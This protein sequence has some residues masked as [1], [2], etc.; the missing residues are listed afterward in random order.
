M[1][2]R[3][4]F[5]RAITIGVG[6]TF[7]VAAHLK[8]QTP[9]TPASLSGVVR[10]VAGAPLVNVNITLEGEG[11]IT[12]TDTAGHFTLANVPTGSHATLF[13][14]I[15]YRSVEYRWVAQPNRGLQ[16]AVAMTPA[17]RALERVVVEAP[18]STRRRGT[19]SIGGTVSDSAGKGV[20]SADVRLLGSGLSTTT[21]SGGTFEFQSLAAGAY[22]VRARRAGVASG[23]YV[24]QLADDDNRGITLKLYGLPKRVGARDS[25][26]ASGYGVADVPFDAF[27]RR[28]RTNARYPILGPADLFRRQGASLDITLQQ[29]RENVP[30]ARDQMNEGDCLIVDGRRATSQPLRTFTSLDVQMVEIFRKN[31]FVDDYVVTQMDGIRECRGTMDHHPPYFVLWTRRLR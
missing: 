21:D 5:A 2:A 25:A 22:I 28:A 6:L 4:S 29:Y 14:R 18:G 1:A 9:A 10:D 8:A 23:N 16:I 30:T 3:S 7:G 24:M 19:S 13:R 31:A 15:G 26:N 20:A 17:P 27:D 11:R 12:Q